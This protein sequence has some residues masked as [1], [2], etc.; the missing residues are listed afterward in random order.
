MAVT[1]ASSS[2]TPVE[3]AE[4]DAEDEAAIA[5]VIGMVER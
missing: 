5:L 3:I 1:Y 4:K 2:G